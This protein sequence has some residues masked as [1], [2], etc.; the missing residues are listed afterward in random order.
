MKKSSHY[1]L[2][3][4]IEKVGIPKTSNLC[5]VKQLHLHQGGGLSPLPLHVSAPADFECLGLISDDQKTH[6]FHEKFISD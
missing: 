1:F 5:D 6:W 3:L 2:L 4:I